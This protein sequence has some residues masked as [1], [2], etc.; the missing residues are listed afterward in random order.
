MPSRDTPV[1]PITRAFVAGKAAL[2]RYVG[3]LNNTVDI[4]D[5][6]QEVICGPSKKNTR[7]PLRTPMPIC[8]KWPE[9]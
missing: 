7:S 5:V 1:S 2:M 4:E 8:L 6:V 3:R 9:M